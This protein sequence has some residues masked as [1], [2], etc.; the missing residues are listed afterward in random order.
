MDTISVK[1]SWHIVNH[2]NASYMNMIDSDLKNYNEE[3]V[4]VP[5]EWN[6]D[7]LSY[8]DSGMNFLTAVPPVMRRIRRGIH[9]NGNTQN[10]RQFNFAGNGI[11]NTDDLIQ[12]LGETV[13]VLDVSFNRFPYNVLIFSHEFSN[14]DKLVTLDLS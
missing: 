8:I 11:E 2:I 3:D 10:I 7:R 1:I 13:I 12:Q 5:N 6:D 14:L 9:F 4:E